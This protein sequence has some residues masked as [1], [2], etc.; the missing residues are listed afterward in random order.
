MNKSVVRLNMY[1]KCSVVPCRKVLQSVASIASP[2]SLQK[3][4]N[5]PH[6]E[7]G[8]RL[9]GLPTIQPGSARHIRE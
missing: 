8:Q 1:W 9:A 3:R 6:H 5:S 2:R 4:A 7:I